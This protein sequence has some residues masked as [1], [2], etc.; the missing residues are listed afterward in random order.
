MRSSAA[1]GQ[2]T[3]FGPP[4]AAPEA[5]HSDHGPVL[6]A[7]PAGA[8]RR[9]S[10]VHPA[11][12]PLPFPGPHVEVRDLPTADLLALLLAPPTAD[13]GGAPA[14][15]GALAAALR[16]ASPG[17]SLRQLAAATSWE[18]AALTGLSSTQVLRL[19]AALD[20][21]R[22]LD[23]EARPERGPCRTARDVYDRFRMRLRDL[24]QEQLWV[25]LLDSRSNVLGESMVSRGTVDASLAHAREIF[26]PAIAEAASSLVLVHNHPSGDPS[27]SDEDREL[28][29]RM[30]LAGIQLSIPLVEHV[31]VG[32][33]R[34][35]SFREMGEL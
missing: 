17:L 35:F 18:L 14:D 24:V 20:L 7:P 27:P 8:R 5:T 21:A 2:I 9:H 15:P 23:R 31:I 19:R 26:R 25:V 22:R 10:P 29:T 4:P 28:T 6:A 33:G 30:R 34:F 3:L 16:K 11:P 13:A 12:G 32:E 1:A